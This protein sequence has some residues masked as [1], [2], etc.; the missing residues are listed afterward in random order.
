M[1]GDCF[2]FVADP[3]LADSNA[4]AQDGSPTH[5]QP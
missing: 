2:L 5:A 4:L 3:G 1:M